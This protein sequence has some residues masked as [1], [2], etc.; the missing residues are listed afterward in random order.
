VK[1]QNV[2]DGDKVAKGYTREGLA[3]AWER[4]LTLPPQESATSATSATD[5]PVSAPNGWDEAEA[6][7]WERAAL[8]AWTAAGEPPGDPWRSAFR[9]LEAARSAQDLPA[10]RIAAQAIVEGRFTDAEE[11]P[12]E[13]EDEEVPF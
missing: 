8:D 4:Y 13:H 11:Y 12:A 10:V 2:R 1:S 5:T 7:R 3:D 9:P 6:A